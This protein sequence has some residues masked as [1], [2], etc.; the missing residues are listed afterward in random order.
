MYVTWQTVITAAA[1]IAAIVAIGKYFTKA[2][3]WYIKLE[4]QDKAIESIMEEQQILVYGVL[5]CLKGLQ[6]QGVD[7]PVTDAVSRIEKHIN[8][9]AHKFETE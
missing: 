3:R 4:G 5:A 9:E 2:H 7:G 1:V 8:K 6:E